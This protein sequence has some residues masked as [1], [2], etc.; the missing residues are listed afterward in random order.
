L[1]NFYLFLNRGFQHET[2]SYLPFETKIAGPVHF[3]HGIYGIFISGGAV[4]GKNCMIFQQVTIGS[5]MLIDSKG[6]GSPVIGDNCLI[7]AGAKVIGNV[8]VGNNC[9]IGANAVVTTDLP[10][11]SVCVAG[12]PVIIQKENLINRIYAIS[13]QGWGYVE[14]GRFVVETDPENLAKLGEL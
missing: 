7:G 2:N 5:N 3:V 14:N 9:R 10:D 12:K 11:N 1:K 8:R 4:I 6:F 13:S